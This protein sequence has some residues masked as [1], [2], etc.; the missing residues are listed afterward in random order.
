MAWVN[1]AL[2]DQD[3]MEMVVSYPEI[4]RDILGMGISGAYYSDITWCQKSTLVSNG[5]QILKF[6]LTINLENI[7]NYYTAITHCY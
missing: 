3:I 7:K 5:L 6:N 4:D 2:I 1:Y